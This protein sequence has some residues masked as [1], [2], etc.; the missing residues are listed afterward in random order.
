MIGAERVWRELGVTGKGVVVGVS[1]TGVD[2][3]HPALRDGFRGGDDSWY[4][5]WEATR[6][7]TDHASHGTH[8]TGTAVGRTGTG[9]APGASWMGCVT[10]NRNLSNPAAFVGCLQFMLAP[11]PPGGDPWRDGRPE[12]APHV[13]NNSWHCTALDGCDPGALAPATAALRAAGLFFVTSAGNTGPRCASIVNAPARYTDVL[14]VGGVDRAGQ[15]AAFANR[16]PRGATGTPV[17]GGPA[18]TPDIAAPAVG[19]PSAMPCGGYGAADGTSMAVPHVS[20]VVALMWSANPRLAGD[21]E[22]TEQILRRSAHPL[23]VAKAADPQGCGIWSSLGAGMVDAYAATRA[24]L[25][26]RP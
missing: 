21:I 11:F 19:V 26:A 17:D 7:P 23:G 22:R 20:G 1:D 18:G 10:G 13:L 16:G 2:G 9:V 4:D 3:R 5:P 6:S 25:A 12:R 24:A 15:V 8:V 14:T